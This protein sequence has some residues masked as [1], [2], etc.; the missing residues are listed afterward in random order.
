VATLAVAIIAVGE[1]C[2]P[3]K[4]GDRQGDGQNCLA[5]HAGSFGRD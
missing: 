4:Q 5:F 1:G 3:G 2:T